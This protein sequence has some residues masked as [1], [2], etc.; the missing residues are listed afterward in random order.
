MKEGERLK[1]VRVHLDMDQAEFCRA[2]DIKST[3][4]LSSIETG[5][6]P[7]SQKLAIKAEQ[8]LNISINWLLNGEG[9]MMKGPSKPILE[10]DSKNSG[11]RLREWR[12]SKGLSQKDVAE[13]TGYQQVAISAAES[14]GR[15]GDKMA[16]KL[17]VAFGVSKVWIKEGIGTMTGALNLTAN[18]HSNN[19]RNKAIDEVNKALLFRSLNKDGSPNMSFVDTK[20]KAG[21]VQGLKDPDYIQELPPIM[22]PGFDQGVYR[23]FEVSGTSMHDTL[24]PD[25]LAI[26]KR[27]D[28]HKE[29]RDDRVHVIVT[30]NDGVLIKRVLNRVGRDGKLIL[31][32]DNNGDGNYPPM[33]IKMT[34]VV[35]LWYVQGR[36]TRHLPHPS[37]TVDRIR[38]LEGDILAQQMEMQELKDLIKKVGKQ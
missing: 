7:L 25:D 12:I 38:S 9:E 18:G 5:K 17:E 28:S 3:P 19:T 1:Q 15:V 27:I 14:R 16:I 4:Y 21:Y 26:C 6:N 2:L 32:S 10:Q 29:I 31:I 13:K 35:E 36:V 8:T 30:K 20:A 33:S 11:E 34:E 37:K 23:V 22:I 24:F